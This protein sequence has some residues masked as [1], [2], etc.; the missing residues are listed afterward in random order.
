MASSNDIAIIGAGF[1]GTLTAVQLL[2]QAKSGLTVYLVERT[3]AQFARGVAYSTSASCHLLN[4]PAGNMSAYPEDAEHFLRWAKTQESTL[5]EPPWVTEISAASFLP[6]RAYG[7]YLRQL[8]EA[9]ERQ[10]APGVRLERVH[11]EAIALT[12]SG[13]GIAVQL[14][15]GGALRADKAVLALGNFRPGNPAV[16]DPSFYETPR[17]HGD[18]WMSALLPDIVRTESCLLIGS[19]LTMVDWALAL[20]AAGYR[21]TIHALS[22][23]GLWPQSHAPYSRLA[24]ELPTSSRPPRMRAWLR[25]V[26]N[27]IRS[28]RCDWRAVV[29]ALRPRTPDLW[30][31]LPLSEQLRFLNHLR[32]YWDCH[33]HRIAPAVASR[34]Q[35]LVESGQLRRHV[36]RIQDFRTAGE[37]VD[38]VIRERGRAAPTVL[39]TEVVLNCSGSESDYRKLDSPLVRNLLRQGLAAP[40]PLRL[41]LKVD[42]R[43][44]LLDH[45][46][47]PSSSLY[48][49]GPP[50][51]GI[52]WETTAVPEIRVQAARLAATLLAPAST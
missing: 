4:V 5:I 9:A 40:D 43:G 23:R 33:R 32:P 42:D 29:D 20:S 25:Q 11:D 14:T 15:Q 34:L 18:P 7:A 35:A 30:Q 21:G 46:E 37:S 24:F 16:A 6:R 19:G 31:S 27:V 48:T 1:S 38:V 26:R 2:R 49:L 47:I 50:Q 28:S 45:R 22:R 39:R 41:G 17:Y 10:A 36:G 44:A 52:L 13:G 51:K 3:P 12:T 8:L